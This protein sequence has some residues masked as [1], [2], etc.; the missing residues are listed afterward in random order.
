MLSNF[1]NLSRP[2]QISIRGVL[3]SD[4][5]G[6]QLQY[7]SWVGVFVLDAPDELRSHSQ[8]LQ[9]FFFARDNLLSTLLIINK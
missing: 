9:D 8:I 6:E 7:R 4:T 2:K 3:P 5:V 1:Q